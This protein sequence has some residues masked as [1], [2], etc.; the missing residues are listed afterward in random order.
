MIHEPS[1]SQKHCPKH[2]P[3]SLLLATFWLGTLG[4]GSFSAY[5]PAIAEDLTIPES[6]SESAPPAAPAPALEP[7]APEAAVAPEP[8]APALPN[9]PATDFYSETAPAAPQ[10]KPVQAEPAQAQSDPDIDTKDYS[11]GATEPY[12]APDN[13]NVVVNERSSGCQATLAAGQ[14]IASNLCGASPAQQLYTMPSRSATQ[15]AWAS[16]PTNWRGSEVSAQTV[17]NTLQY[18][19]APPRN[20]S[21]KPATGSNPLK[22]ILP[23]GERMIFPLT[24]PVDI[25]SVFG[26]RV[27]PVTGEWRFHS[28]TDLG[29]P[30]GTPV[31]AAYSGRVSLAEFLGGYGLSIL[32]DHNQGSEETR[33]GHL[34]EIFVKP[35]QWVQQGTVIGLV[36]STGNSTGPHLHFETLQANQGSL[37]AVDPT[38]ELQT[39]LTQ[40]ATAL[41]TARLTAKSP[42]NP[43]NPSV[44]LTANQPT[45]QLASRLAK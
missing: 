34:S 33:Y 40:L 42:A 35:G 11:I 45:K 8:A 24:I 31:L 29:A 6:A 2:R 20:L 17:Q 9:E 7:A 16:V 36:G 44:N 41:Q 32:L 3:Q 39:T 37:V 26:W 4:L 22:W 10:A 21:I 19:V 30:M 28:G 43:A 12:N 23:N 5:G 38:M 1:E 18:S 14:A 27:H 13:V 15:P 25:T